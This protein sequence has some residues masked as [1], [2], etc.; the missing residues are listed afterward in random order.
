[1][2]SRDKRLEVGEWVRI[3]TGGFDYGRVTAIDGD[4]ATVHVTAEMDE[5]G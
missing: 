4:M 1:M 3:V 5:W 2:S